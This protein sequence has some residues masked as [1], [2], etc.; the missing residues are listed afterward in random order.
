[1]RPLLR[2]LQLF[3]LLAGEEREEMEERGR[4][5]GQ[6]PGLPGCDLMLLSQG[7]TQAVLSRPEVG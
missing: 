7:T 2:E 3:S 4:G 6:L 5:A 1:M